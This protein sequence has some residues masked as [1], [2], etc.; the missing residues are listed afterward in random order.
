VANRAVFLD[1]DGTINIEKGYVHC[2]DQWE[3][4]PGAV[5]A[6]VALKK[7][8]FLVIIVTNQAGIARGYYNET[9]MANLHAWINDE[10]KP[11]G[12]VIDG[13]YHC[14]HHPEF[15]TIRECECRKP[16][17]G[18]IFEASREFDIDLGRSWLVG[19]K[20]SDIQAGLAAGVQSILVLTGYGKQDRALLEDNGICVADIAE[21]VS[22]IISR[23]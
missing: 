20:V 8:G 19:D 13:F 2:I 5:D 17:P 22:Y 21:A 7:A 11:H 4:I 3:W 9:D 6:I 14:P 10:L 16:M 23:S 15:G 1:R 12:A 18:M